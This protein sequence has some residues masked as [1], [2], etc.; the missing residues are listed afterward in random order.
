MY[1]QITTRCNMRCAHCCFSCTEN[2]I[3]MSVDMFTRALEW[4]R[5]LNDSSVTIGGGEPTI[6]PDFEKFV[7][8]AI[9]MLKEP[10]GIVT[11]GKER[12]KALW[13]AKMNKIGRLHASLSQDR[14]HEP[15]EPDVVEAFAVQWKVKE[16]YDHQ[17]PIAIG[18]GRNIPDARR[19]YHC[20]GMEPLVSPDGLIHQC[21]CPDSTILG[22]VYDVTRVQYIHTCGSPSLAV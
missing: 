14:F 16:I 7:E 5:R 8:Q 18:R 19:Q 22:N 1:I 9:S 17:Q 11:N 15:V 2:G 12:E 13:L 6:H 3:D 4:S 10:I 20:W 21:Y